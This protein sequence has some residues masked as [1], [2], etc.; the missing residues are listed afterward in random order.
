M[1]DIL[2]VVTFVMGALCFAVFLRA[3]QAACPQIDSAVGAMVDEYLSLRCPNRLIMTAEQ[4][5]QTEREP[6]VAGTR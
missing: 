4:G 5:S 6:R 2:T 1:N 3:G